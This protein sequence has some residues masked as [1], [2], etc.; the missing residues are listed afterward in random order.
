M[1]NIILV[2][3]SGCGKSTLGKFL[4]EK[5]NIPFLDTDKYIEKKENMSIDEIFRTKGE[6]YFR[7]LE[8]DILKDLENFNGIISTGGGL[9]V[10][11]NNMYIL[12]SL[13]NTIFLDVN[14]DICIKRILNDKSRPLAKKG[15]VYLRNLYNER[16]TIYKKA[17]YTIECT[18]KTLNEIL[19]EMYIITKN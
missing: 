10:F 6:K 7:Y 2:G 5:L 19:Q 12:N 1:K 11:N 3:M 18:Y 16:K 14:V 13:G 15:N 8:N 9:P 17:Q 4:S